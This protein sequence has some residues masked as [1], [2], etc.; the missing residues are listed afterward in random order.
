MDTDLTITSAELIEH[1]GIKVSTLEGWIRL[2]LVVYQPPGRGNPRQ[3][4]FHEVIAASIA[5]TVMDATVQVQIGREFVETYWNAVETNSLQRPA[6]ILGRAVRGGTCFW[7]TPD[8]E[9][10][11]RN[12]SVLLIA[13]EGIFME[14]EKYF[15]EIERERSEKCA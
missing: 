14:T 13:T 7:M 12:E 9:C 4:G 11:F 1:L 8:N 15:A 6:W 3:F 2:G 10:D 5:K